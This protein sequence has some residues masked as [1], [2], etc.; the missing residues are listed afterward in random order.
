MIAREPWAYEL[1]K[2]IEA[3][4]FW[5]AEIDLSRRQRLAAP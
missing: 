4:D 1:L 5:P 2:R 3:R